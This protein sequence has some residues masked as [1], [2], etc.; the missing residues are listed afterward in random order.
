M[1]NNLPRY[2]END[3]HADKYD[4]RCE[5]TCTDLKRCRNV[6]IIPGK[7]LDGSI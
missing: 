7:E 2:I 6:G 1:L 5:F 3:A 4:S